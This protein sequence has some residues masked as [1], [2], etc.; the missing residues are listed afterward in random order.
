VEVKAFFC[1]SRCLPASTKPPYPHGTL[2]G[3]IACI[4]IVIPS[5]SR[6]IP[7]KDRV[8]NYAPRF[9][10]AFLFSANGAAF[11]GSLGQRPRVAFQKIPALK[12]RFNRADDFPCRE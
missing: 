10:G 5:E 3:R 12:A 11:I 7:W 4:T 1:L 8:R 9:V 2:A 6:A